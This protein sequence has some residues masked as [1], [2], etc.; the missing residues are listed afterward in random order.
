MGEEDEERDTMRSMQQKGRNSRWDLVSW[1][2]TKHNDMFPMIH[3]SVLEFMCIRG[4]ADGREEEGRR[5]GTVTM[6]M[7]SVYP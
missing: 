5:N 1:L 4:G 2:H 3:Q 6:G 7:E